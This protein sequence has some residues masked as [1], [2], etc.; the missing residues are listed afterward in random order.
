MLYSFLNK[1]LG[2]GR[3][4][5]MALDLVHTPHLDLRFYTVVLDSLW[6]V[7]LSLRFPDSVLLINKT[8]YRVDFIVCWP[9]TPGKRIYDRFSATLGKIWVSLMA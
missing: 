5:P 9:E 7:V 4:S 3:F 6:I 8:V 2:P 1:C